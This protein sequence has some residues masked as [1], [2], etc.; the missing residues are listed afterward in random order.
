V[1]RYRSALSVMIKTDVFS[2]TQEHQFAFPPEIL[3]TLEPGD[4]YLLC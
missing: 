1:N 2:I 3:E 4:E